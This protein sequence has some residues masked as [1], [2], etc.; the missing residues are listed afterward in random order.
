MAFSEFATGTRRLRFHAAW[1]TAL[2]VMCRGP[3]WT[4]WRSVRSL[5]LEKQS[6]SK[7]EAQSDRGAGGRR[8]AASNH[9]VS[10]KRF[11]L[12]V[13]LAAAMFT[14]V[15]LIGATPRASA[16]GSASGSYVAGLE[17]PLRVAI[18]DYRARYG[19][20]PLLPSLALA[21]AARAHVVSM[22]ELGYFSHTSA[23][24]TVFWK[25]V[26]HFYPSVGYGTWAVAEDLLWT[27]SPVTP[28]QALQMWIDSPE[29]RELLLRAIYRQVGIATI[30]VAAAPGHFDRLNV[31]I[32]DADFGGRIR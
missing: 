29:H 25:R 7:A 19:L 28:K 13:L 16:G 6:R 11:R 8:G 2:T 10:G 30:E 27:S 5:F 21:S 18:N 1:S 20:R 23:D 3:W 31:T 15:T 9:G 17:V 14:A 12:R 26:Q 4:V 24:G 22:G 32:I